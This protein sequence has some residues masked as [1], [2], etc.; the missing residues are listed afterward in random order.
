MVWS[1]TLCRKKQEILA[2]TGAWYHGGQAKPVALD[3][4]AA[5]GSETASTKTD[6]S[7]PN[8][9]KPKFVEQQ[10]DSGQSSEKENIEKREQGGMTRAMSLHG[11]ELK[12]QYSLDA[13]TKAHETKDRAPDRA[14]P[15][16]LDITEQE[17]LRERGQLPE[18]G[19][20]R[21]RSPAAHRHHSESRLSETDRRYEKERRSFDRY[22]NNRSK[23]IVGEK[24]D[25]SEV[26]DKQRHTDERRRSHEREK[27]ESSSERMSDREEIRERKRDISRDRDGERVR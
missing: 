1:C 27:K 6:I 19:R 18:R 11:R 7:P 3:V 22:G 24:N 2:K 9:K 14:G 13:Q 12:R 8:E 26:R 15:G 10:L 23:E 21:D 25:R 4:D 16:H 5:S 17:K 20:T